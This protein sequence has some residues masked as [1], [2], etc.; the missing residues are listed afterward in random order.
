[1]LDFSW[2]FHSHDMLWWFSHEKMVMSWHFPWFFLCFTTST[3]PHGCFHGCVAS[4]LP[5]E[6]RRWGGT[7]RRPR[8][9]GPCGDRW[10]PREARRGAT[11]SLKP[12]PFSL[13]ISDNIWNIY[14]IYMKYIWNMMDIWWISTYIWD[15][16]TG[17]KLGK[18]IIIYIYEIWWIST[19]I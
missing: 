5:A 11:C 8:R 9:R 18:Y 14:E 17:V 19:Y 3:T 1:M 7:E 6:S 10:R 12:R 13:I 2:S 15:N 16:Q 4:H